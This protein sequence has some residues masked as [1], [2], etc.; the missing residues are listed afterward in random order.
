[1]APGNSMPKQHGL[2]LSDSDLWVLRDPKLSSQGNALLHPP[3]P[4]HHF[5]LQYLQQME[6]HS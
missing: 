1:M 5:H 4:G 2:G 3:G 6:S